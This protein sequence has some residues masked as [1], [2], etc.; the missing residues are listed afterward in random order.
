MYFTIHPQNN[1][2]KKENPAPSSHIPHSINQLSPST[3]STTSAKLHR[4]VRTYQDRP[5]ASLDHQHH[6]HVRPASA[7]NNTPFMSAAK[8]QTQTQTQTGT[9]T[10]NPNH[11]P[12]RKCKCRHRSQPFKS[13]HSTSATPHPHTPPHLPPTRLATI[14]MRGSTWVRVRVRGFGRAIYTSRDRVGREEGSTGVG[15]VNRRAV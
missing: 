11:K 15:G 2:D 13:S 4:Q 1:T 7:E 3:T 5:M 12:K 9:G 10:K 6:E 14:S 8:T